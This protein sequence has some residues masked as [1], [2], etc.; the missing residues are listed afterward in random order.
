MLKEEKRFYRGSSETIR[1]GCTET[2]SNQDILA[3]N[4]YKDKKNAQLFAHW[5]AGLI[6]TDGCFLVSK[7]GYTSCEITVGEKEWQTLALIK[8]KLG[9]SIKKRSNVKALRWRLHNVDGMINLVNM[10]NGNLLLY[11]RKFQLSKVC[12]Q[13]EIGG[14]V[15][16]KNV[17]FPNQ[18]LCNTAWLAGFFEGEG[19]FH[20]NKTTYQLSITL[21]QKDK[22][23]LDEIARFMGGNVFYDKSW[24]GWLYAA[25]H[26]N[27]IAVWI[28]YFTKHPLI[29][30]KQ[31]QLKRFIKLLLY[32]SR[33]IHF[34]KEGKPWL[35]FKRLVCDF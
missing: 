6:D 29:S 5:L 13:L 14:H 33:K 1:A 2:I 32:K 31:I 20:L 30:W 26:K 24:N 16:S 23:L 10:V 4:K 28:K 3:K 12:N 18:N 15:L 7:A 9:G 22:S 17:F 27:D 21:S 35:R 34:K 11:Q 25:S 19:N 8:H